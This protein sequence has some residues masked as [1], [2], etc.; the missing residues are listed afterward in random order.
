MFKERPGIEVETMKQIHINIGSSPTRP[1]KKLH[2]KIKAVFIG[3]SSV[4]A[5]GA[6][7]LYQRFR[8]DL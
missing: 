5:A 4:D 3:A 6:R 8:Q 7:L 2:T 1:R